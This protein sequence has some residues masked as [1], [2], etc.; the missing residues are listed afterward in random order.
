MKGKKWVFG[1]TLI[2]RYWLSGLTPDPHETNE[3]ISKA[4]VSGEENPQ[5]A[6]LYQEVCSLKKILFVP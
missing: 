4:V 2:L 1:K 6:Y 5:L 3:E